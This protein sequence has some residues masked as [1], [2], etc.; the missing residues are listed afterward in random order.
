MTISEHSLETKT[1]V[2][3]KASTTESTTIVTTTTFQTTDQNLE[4]STKLNYVQLLARSKKL[5]VDRLMDR[6]GNFNS[7]FEYKVA[8]F[9]QTIGSIVVDG[10]NSKPRLVFLMET[11][12]QQ[13]V[14]NSKIIADLYVAKYEKMQKIKHTVSFF[15]LTATI[16]LLALGVFLVKTLF[17]MHRSMIFHYE[18]LKVTKEKRK[19]RLKQ[20]RKTGPSYL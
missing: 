17:L 18:K 20:K 9:H 1:S 12:L 5:Y 3:I 4:T 16:A 2:K 19:K 13:I 14:K 10:V 8:K 7:I 11:D 6:L 15:K